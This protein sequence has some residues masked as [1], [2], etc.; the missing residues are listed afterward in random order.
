MSRSFPERSQGATGRE[1]ETCK[2]GKI[3]SSMETPRPW[4]ADFGSLASYVL[5]EL[6]LGHW[7]GDGGGK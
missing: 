7:V 4:S 2:G 3:K 1:H 5:R 6:P